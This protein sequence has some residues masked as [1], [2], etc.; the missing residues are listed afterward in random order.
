M[1]IEARKQIPSQVNRFQMDEMRDINIIEWNKKRK[2][3]GFQ[4]DLIR[5]KH[6]CRV[7]SSS[8]EDESMIDES[9][10]LESANNHTVN[11]RTDAAFLDDRSEHESAKD[12]NSFIEDS[13]TSMSVNDD[14]K[15][16]ADSANTS[17]CVNRLNYSE[18]ETFDSKYNPSYD[19]PDT[20]AME[21]PEQHLLIN[22]E[23]VKDSS[24]DQLIDKELEEFLISHGVIPDK[25][26]LSSGILIL[27]QTEADSSIRPPTIDEEFEEYFSALM[28]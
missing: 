24:D 14:A 8:S 19:D 9:P 20:Q 15:L 2:L 26:A 3:Q 22:S 6:K 16:E 4:L 1:E 23:Y 12:S 10:I 28:L 11:R 5:P 7:E 27:N 17:L 21:I 13:D 18:D 25:Y